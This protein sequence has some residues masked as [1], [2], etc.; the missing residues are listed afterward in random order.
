MVYAHEH[1]MECC[2]LFTKQGILKYEYKTGVLQD[3]ILEQFQKAFISG[4]PVQKTRWRK[5]VFDTKRE[6]PSNF[7]DIVAYHMDN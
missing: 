5:F 6:I 1:M 4:T 3:T 7:N 2:I